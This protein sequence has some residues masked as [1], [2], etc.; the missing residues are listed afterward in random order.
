MLIERKGKLPGQMLGKSPWLQS[1]HLMTDAAV[2]DL[3]EVEIVRAGPNS[4]SASNGSARGARPPLPEARR[5][6]FWDR[7]YA[8]ARDL[9]TAEQRDFVRAAM[10][11]STAPV[12][13]ATRRTVVPQGAMNQYSPIAGEALLLQCTAR[14]S[15]RSPRASLLPAYAFWPIVRARRASCAGT[16]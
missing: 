6:A 14:R 1:V 5:S 7:G 12:R 4:L 8:V 10:D 16:T 3:V 13:C 2:G 9:R 15:R 11:V